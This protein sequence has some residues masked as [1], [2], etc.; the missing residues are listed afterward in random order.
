MARSRLLKPGFFRNELL[1]ELPH[2]TRL[3]FA[4]LWGIA[5]RE[6]R[7][8]DRPKRIAADV[9][10]YENLEVDAMLDALAAAGFIVRYV[11]AEARYIAIPTF[12]DHQCPHLR[13]APSTIPAPDQHS[14]STVLALDQ[15]SPRS[16]VSV[17][18]PKS[19]PKT[20]SGTVSVPVSVS[21]SETVTRAARARSKPA[22]D[23]RLTALARELLREHP[24]E[25][26]DVLIDTLQWTAKERFKIEIKRREAID[27]LQAA[28]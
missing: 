10:P 3:L 4:G 22:G 6:G 8:D 1:C 13:E 11:V 27:Y 2:A 9:F 5:D 17:S 16:P 19:V 24:N 7:L 18:V 15:A 23:G 12:L 21:K 25:P 28:S 14:A 26:Q 20:E